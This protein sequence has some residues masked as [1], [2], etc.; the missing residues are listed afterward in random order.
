[1]GPDAP[2]R[3]DLVEEAG[4]WSRVDTGGR[5]AA[6][7]ESVSGRLGEAA[8]TVAL[9]L[10]DDDLV[11]D[12]NRRFRGKDSATNVLSF[13]DD[14]GFPSGNSQA[15]THL[16]DVI[17]AIETLSREAKRDEKSIDDHFTHLVVHGI[18]HLIG[19]DHETDE[20]AEEM[21]SLET[22]IL[23]D[24]GIA[25]PYADVALAAGDH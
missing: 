9:V 5:V 18:L 17:L 10:A 16:G 22:A 20:D 19:Y 21:E 25:D 8:G 23:D 24:L 13:P 3:I 7:A 2:L 6:I 11:R 1:M 15:D 14:D 4:D 12:L